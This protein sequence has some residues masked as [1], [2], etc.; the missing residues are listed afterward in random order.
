MIRPEEKSLLTILRLSSDN[1]LII[2]SIDQKMA[3]I[4]PVNF[5]SAIDFRTNKKYVKWVLIP[6]LIIG[7][8]FVSG[9]QYILTESSA[10]I[11]KHNTFFEPKAPFNYQINEEL[12]CIQFEDYLLKIKVVLSK[13]V[14]PL[15]KA[16][17]KREM[18]MC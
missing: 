6:I 5:N 18:F 4:K 15:K 9:K 17:L 2:A 8:F 7:L 1:D 13:E 11:V 16:I 14:M 10:R 12:K 3:D